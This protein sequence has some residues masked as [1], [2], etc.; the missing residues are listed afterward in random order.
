MTSNAVAETTSSL[1]PA[2]VPATVSSSNA[3][4]DNQEERKKIE[5]AKSMQ[6]VEN[7]DITDD[8]DP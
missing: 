8:T 4:D 6:E 2:P 1:A 3:N 5:E 7:Y